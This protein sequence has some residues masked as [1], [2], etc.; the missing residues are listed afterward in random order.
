MNIQVWAPSDDNG[1]DDD[2]DDDDTAIR[3]VGLPTNGT[4]P[5]FESSARLRR[6]LTR[7]SWKDRVSSH[8][9]QQRTSALDSDEADIDNCT[10]DDAGEAP[11]ELLAHHHI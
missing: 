8:Q 9:W 7:T 2:N 10:P 11:G 4:A 6:A 3:S 1:D 5:V